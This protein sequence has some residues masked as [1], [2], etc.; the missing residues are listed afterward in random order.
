MTPII[1]PDNYNY[2]GVFLTLRCNLNCSYCINHFNSLSST[3]ELS[4]NTWLEGLSRIQTRQDLPITF[5]GGEPTIHAGFYP[6]ILGLYKMGK[7]MDLL[8]NGTF[9]LREFCHFI[10]PDLFIRDAKYACIRFSF[11]QKTNHALAYKVWTM[12]NS[13]YNV[14]VWGV[15]H[16]GDDSKD[17][18]KEMRDI[19]RWLNIDYREKEFLGESGGHLYGTYKYPDACSKKFKRRVWCKPSE[20][21]INPAGYIFRCHADLYANRDYIGHILDDEIKF[22]GFMECKNYGYCNPCDVKLKTN[23]LQESG[24][25]AVEIRGKEVIIT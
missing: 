7:H 2:I 15:D 24:Y 20:L 13:G 23:R 19:C 16:P 6:I 21:L 4:S 8:T 11:H 10:S 9:D 3:E 25:C 14:G 17:R 1:L 18:N 5:Q 22:P 12:Q